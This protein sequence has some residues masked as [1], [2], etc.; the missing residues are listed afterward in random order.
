MIRKGELVFAADD[1]FIDVIRV[2]KEQGWIRHKH[3][4]FP[5]CDLKWI[6]YAKVRWDRIRPTQWINHI[7]NS[8]ELSN[9]A[10]LCRY[11]RQIPGYDDYIPSTWAVEDESE[12]NGFLGKPKNTRF[13][14]KIS[15]Q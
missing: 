12:L 1:K 5:G 11:L 13:R 10:K 3:I 9:K 6:N 14:S 2:L 4:Q 8:T 15:T 7:K